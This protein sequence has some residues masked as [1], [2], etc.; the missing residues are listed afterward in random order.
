MLKNYFIVYIY[1]TVSCII[2]KYRVICFF[3]LYNYSD[4]DV[5]VKEIKS[6]LRTR[7]KAEV[8]ISKF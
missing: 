2:Y 3:L 1:L 5:N 6:S 4:I 7:N 8:L